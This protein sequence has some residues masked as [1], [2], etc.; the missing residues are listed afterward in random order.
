MKTVFEESFPYVPY[1]QIIC[2]LGYEEEWR[3]SFPLQ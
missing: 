3:R 1:A 2:I